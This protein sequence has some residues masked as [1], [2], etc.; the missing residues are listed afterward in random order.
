MACC[1]V[2]GDH[3][4]NWIANVLVALVAIGLGSGYYFASASS[5]PTVTWAKNPLYVAFSSQVGS[6]SGQDSFKCSSTI[7]PVTLQVF[8]S[9]P[10]TVAVTVGPSAF[11]SC[12]STPN[13]VVVTATCTASARA[14]HSCEENFYGIV[15]VCGPSSYNCLRQILVV[16]VNIS[17]SDDQTVGH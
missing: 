9:E 11:P 7:A 16:I 5:S 3:I 8:S 1:R 17:N 12:G 13:N 10:D 4:M 14:E 6:G 2:R 15:V